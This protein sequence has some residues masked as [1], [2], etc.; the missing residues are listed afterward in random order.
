[1]LMSPVAPSLP[2]NDIS[3]LSIDCLPAVCL[4]FQDSRSRPRMC[5]RVCVY[6]CTVCRSSIHGTCLEY[7]LLRRIRGGNRHGRP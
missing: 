4:Y 1:M 6:V 2:G 5:V 7:G 3:I